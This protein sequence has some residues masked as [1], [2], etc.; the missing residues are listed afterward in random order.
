MRELVRC[1]STHKQLIAVAER[2]PAHGGLSAVEA[3][4]QCIDSGA[5]FDGWGFDAAS[6]PTAAALAD[7]L[8]GQ[9]PAPARGV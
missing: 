3:R 8:L 9:V 5:K 1:V 7:A 6:V 4:Q 2:D